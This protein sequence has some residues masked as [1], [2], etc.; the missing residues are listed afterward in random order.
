[1]AAHHRQDMRGGVLTLSALCIPL[2]PPLA[3]PLLL[4][5]HA[6]DINLTACFLTAQAVLPRMMEDDWGRIVNIASVHGLVARLV[7]AFFCCGWEVVGL[8]LGS[9][10]HAIFV[11]FSQGCVRCCETWSCGSYEGCSFV[12]GYSCCVL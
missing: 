3:P 5:S 4:S 12:S 6:P 10:L 11:Q 9:H 8:D 2:L 1:M 7:I